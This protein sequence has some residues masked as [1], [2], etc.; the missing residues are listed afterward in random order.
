MEKPHIE[1]LPRPTDFK[2]PSGPH[3]GKTV[4]LMWTIDTEDPKIFKGLNANFKK[5]AANNR[6]TIIMH[7]READMVMLDYRN[8]TSE[9]QDI[10]DSWFM[11][12]T[13]EQKD[14]VIIM[15]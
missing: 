5:F 14:G 6:Q 12:M 4:N 1:N 11:S 15:R 9:N 7:L 13:P 2:F 10:V 8:L 3:K